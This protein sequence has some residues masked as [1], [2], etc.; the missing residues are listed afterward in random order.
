[1]GYLLIAAS[2]TNL[3]L[4]NAALLL[5]GIMGA[6]NPMDE[7]LGLLFKEISNFLVSGIPKKYDHLFC[8]ILE[9][10]RNGTRCVYCRISNDHY[11]EEAIDDPSN[12]F[13]QLGESH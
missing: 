6:M 4:V 11:P 8:E 13:L 9:S 2:G 12:Q 5:R 10:S 7:S 3:V 1:M